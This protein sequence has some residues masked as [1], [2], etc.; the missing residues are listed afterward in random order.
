MGELVG[1][2]AGNYATTVPHQRKSFYAAGRFWVFYSDGANMV[3]CTSTD[4]LNWTSP[5][6]VR[7]SATRGHRFSIWFDETY[8]HYVYSSGIVNTPV[9]Y[10]RGI[11]ESDGS[12]TWSA[13]EQTAIAAVPSI[14]NN[15]TSVSVDSGGYAW[16]GYSRLDLAAPYPYDPTSYVTKSSTTTGIWVTDGGFPYSFPSLSKLTYISIIP[17]TDNKMLAVYVYNQNE[18]VRANLWDGA[19]WGSEVATISEIMAFLYFSAVAEGD[20]VHLV[21]KSRDPDYSLIYVKYDYST[22][23]FTAEKVLV[24]GMN[25]WSAPVLSIDENNNLYVF[26]GGSPDAYSVYYIIYTAENDTWGPVVKWKSG[27]NMFGGS[28]TCFYKGY[29]GYTGLVYTMNSPPFDIKFNYVAPPP[30]SGSTPEPGEPGSPGA[31]LP[32]PEPVVE[33]NTLTTSGARHTTPEEGSIGKVESFN[34]TRISRHIT[35]VPVIIVKA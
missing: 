2:S 11:P 1:T 32:T 10:R 30:P 22:N 16:I 8:L 12:I 24:T 3:Y 5:E 19:A 20:D 13:V 28:F 31:P 27:E 21:F 9:F 18:R 34:D 17:L 15:Y 14:I 7:L 6:T 4:G 26:W 29:S 33:S 25:P 23:S 35:W